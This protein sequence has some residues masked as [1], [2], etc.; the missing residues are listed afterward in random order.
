[1]DNKT[2]AS[3][4]INTEKEP[5]TISVEDI[6]EIWKKSFAMI[7]TEPKVFYFDI[8]P[9][10]EGDKI[11]LRVSDTLKKYEFYTE[12]ENLTDHAIKLLD[13]LLDDPSK[14]NLLYVDETIE[15]VQR[16]IQ[17]D[18]M[19][20]REPQLF[21]NI[22]LYGKGFI[23]IDE[24]LADIF[25]EITVTVI[26]K[27]MV[28]V[29]KKAIRNINKEFLQNK[30]LNV[31][32]M[33]NDSKLAFRIMGPP[34]LETEETIYAK[35]KQYIFNFISSYLLKEP[36]EIMNNIIGYDEELENDFKKIA[37]NELNKTSG[38]DNRRAID[39]F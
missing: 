11:K 38:Q 12:E 5:I 37:T 19:A 6:E 23:K 15:K 24:K 7:S 20:M 2:L 1:M 33:P 32:F 8:T 26:D 27:K 22:R 3:V 35:G 28:F 25:G 21:K 16:R 10:I 36:D 39:I 31:C 4:Q 13:S 9:I 18:F 17:V 29:C 30:M 34:F 14:Q